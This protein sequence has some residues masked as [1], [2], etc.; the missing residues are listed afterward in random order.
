MNSNSVG[1]PVV[2]CFGHCA[3]ECV[4][5]N[6]EEED[7][8]QQE[9][10]KVG[11][12]AETDRERGKCEKGRRQKGEATRRTNR[13]W[14]K[15]RKQ[16]EIKRGEP[17]E[18]EEEDVVKQEQAGNVGGEKAHGKVMMG[19]FEGGAEVGEAQDW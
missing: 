9:E 11:G 15:T 5:G 8:D 1:S 12:G 17:E 7:E 19:G 6:S 13:R 2:C 14:T 10:Q 3:A 18:D 4:C 16:E